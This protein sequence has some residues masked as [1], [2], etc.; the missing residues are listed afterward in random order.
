MPVTASNNE[1]QKHADELQPVDKKT[2]D[3][4]ADSAAVRSQVD[5]SKTPDTIKAAH[6]PSPNRQAVGSNRLSNVSTRHDLN[7]DS[8]MLGNNGQTSHTAAITVP[9]AHSKTIS[10][11]NVAHNAN[12]SNSNK[13]QKQLFLDTK[14]ASTRPMTP[15]SSSSNR[16][17][18]AAPALNSKASSIQGDAEQ[19]DNNTEC[20]KSIPS[21]SKTGG[22]RRNRKDATTRKHNK[23][24]STHKTA[25]SHS[26]QIQHKPAAVKITGS[27]WL[28][29]L[30]ND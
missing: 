11:I 9:D 5:S 18:E 12:N 29:C 10:P 2:T 19:P 14:K 8:K 30:M 25:G 23:P 20:S 28:V 6:S 17:V 3:I 21:N 15:N 13:I 1:S 27:S 7:N 22:R 24:T 16:Q 4:V 26:A